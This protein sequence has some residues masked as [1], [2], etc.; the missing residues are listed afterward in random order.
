M[1][2]EITVRTSPV[3]I[4]VI[5]QAGIQGPPGAQGVSGNSNVDLSNLVTR[6]ETGQ[7]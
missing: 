3:S 4:D 1:A 7:F 6:N 2:I 5:Q